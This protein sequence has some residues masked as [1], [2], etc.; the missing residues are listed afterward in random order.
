M[1]QRENI[2]AGKGEPFSLGEGLDFMRLLWAIDHA[3]QSK[4]K[5]MEAGLGVTGLQ[6]LVIRI[7]GRFPGIPAGQLAEILQIHPST[8]TGVVKRL[9]RRKLIRRRTDARDGRRLLLGL[10]ARGNDLDVDAEGSIES[11]V[12]GVLAGIPRNQLEATQAVLTRLAQ[13]LKE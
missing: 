5:S 11:A 4:S 7:V 8:L 13:S 1:K 3:I 6:R 12:Q 10:T 9:E 2:L